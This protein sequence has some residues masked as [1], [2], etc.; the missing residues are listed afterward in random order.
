MYRMEVSLTVNLILHPMIR[1]PVQ[2]HTG[3]PVCEGI[4]DRWSVRLAVTV[5][6]GT[7][8]TDERRE[9]I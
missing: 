2:P 9:G 8:G 4:R 7:L 6:R 5:K 1:R 3:S